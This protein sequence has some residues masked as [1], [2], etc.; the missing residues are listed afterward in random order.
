M[1]LHF[2]NKID[3]EVET[4]FEALSYEGLILDKYAIPA[5]KAKAMSMYQK[6]IRFKR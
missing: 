4:F 3:F 2:D 5:I 1:D 6:Q